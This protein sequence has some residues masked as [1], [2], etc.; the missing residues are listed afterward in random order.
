MLYMIGV[1]RVGHDWATSLSLSCIGEGDGSPLQCSC[2]E[3]PRGGRAWWA[4]V[5][6]IA[7]SRTRLKWLSSSSSSSS[8]DRQNLNRTM[9]WNM[10]YFFKYGETIVFLL[11]TFM[12]AGNFPL[13]LPTLLS[14]MS[15]TAPQGRLSALMGRRWGWAFVHLVSVFMPFVHFILYYTLTWIFYM[16]FSSHASW[17]CNIPPS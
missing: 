10:D 3:N 7:Q 9:E 1:A 5:S 6:G 17:P 2:L 13:V 14:S 4:A 16:V 11:K 15:H 12:R 8:P